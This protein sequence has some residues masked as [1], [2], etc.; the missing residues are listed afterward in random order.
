MASQ[1]KNDWKTI[2]AWGGIG[3][4]LICVIKLDQDELKEVIC[5]CADAAKEYMIAMSNHR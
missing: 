1:E 3:I 5:H 4:V 2:A